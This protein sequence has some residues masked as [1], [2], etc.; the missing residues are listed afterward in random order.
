MKLSKK[1]ILCFLC[2]ALLITTTGASCFGGSSTSSGKEVTLEM[3]GVFDSPDVFA[4]II[5]DYQKDH[6]N[7]KI[8]YTQ[9]DYAEYEDDSLN[10]L[11]EGSGPD[12]WMIK[13]DW[14][15]RNYQKLTPMPDGLLSSGDK[16][17]RT[18][19]QVLKDTFAPVVS[20]DVIINDKIYGLPP[21]VDTL[22]LYYN[23]ELF[24]KKSDSLSEQKN[25]DQ[26]KFLQ[27]PPSNWDEIIE[28]TKLLT[29]RDGDTIKQSGI[30][31]GNSDNVDQAVDILSVLM[32]QNHANMVSDD[33]K[34]ATFNQPIKKQDGS[35]YYPGTQAL[36]F[37]T[38]FSNTSK[39]TYSWN[40][41]MGADIDLFIQGKV[42][43]IL[44]YQFRQQTIL[45]ANPNLN[46]GI[47]PL[48]QIKGETTAIDYA[49]Y[50]VETV[51]KKCSNSDVAWDFIHYLTSTGLNSYLSA[52]K[53]PSPLINNNVP[54]ATQRSQNASNTFGFQVMSA[55]D[56]YKGK[57]P[58]KVDQIFMNL[59]GNVAIN[60]QNTQNAIDTAASN[61]TTL[62]SK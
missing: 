30:A 28:A 40:A 34:S 23:K 51:T 4:P 9:K 21:Y 44:D 36:D 53:R 18:D 10:A 62:L 54:E 42:A 5:A 48:P 27:N 8:N 14:F 24:Q 39:E 31:M 55:K 19:V 25:T 17:K 37:Y 35:L 15:P 20:T 38:S 60:K 45:Q 7:V 43:M 6:P 57:Y 52:T 22:A 1:L 11:A 32:L 41:T 50:W 61:V 59:I 16:Q 29:L 3:W 13:N 26:S 46:Y 58:S 49:N 12:I 2:C 56:W 47:A 33:K